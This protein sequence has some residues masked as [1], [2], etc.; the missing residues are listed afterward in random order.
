MGDS[1]TVDFKVMLRKGAKARSVQV[2]PAYRK[3]SPV[4][5]LH[6]MLTVIRQT[7]LRECAPLP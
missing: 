6:R 5:L 2:R 1:R 7:C 4:S 3:L